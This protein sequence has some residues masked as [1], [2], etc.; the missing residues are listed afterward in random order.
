MGN[1]KYISSILF[2]ALLSCLGTKSL[3]TKNPVQLESLFLE[4]APKIPGKIQCEF[5]NLG[6][7]GIGYHDVDTINHGSGNL[8]KGKDYLS[9]FRQEEA[10]DISFTKYHDSIDNSKYNRVQPK[11]GQLYLGWT[12]PG[13]WTKYTVDVQKSGTYQIGLIYTANQNG[14]I[15]IESEDKRSSGILTVEST[16]DKDD[17]IAWRQWHHWNFVENLGQIHLKNGIQTITLHTVSVG[18]MN[19]DFIEFKLVNK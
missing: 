4:K 7:E 13:E 10:P 18:Q 5:Y 3:Q 6:G 1:S 15:S 19:Y 11:E 16:F 2:S 17:P 12:E 8:N 9:T 14:Q